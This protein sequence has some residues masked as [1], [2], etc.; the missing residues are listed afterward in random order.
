MIF[1]Q[2][3]SIFFIFCLGLVFF[4]VY[5]PDLSAQKQED[6]NGNW[7]NE[8]PLNFKL[9]FVLGYQEGFKVALGEIVARDKNLP[10]S[11]ENLSAQSL[12]DQ[13]HLKIPFSCSQITE[14][15]NRFYQEDSN[16]PINI[17]SAI[18]IA[19]M[20]LQK[21]SE[22]N[23]QKAIIKYRNANDLFKKGEKTN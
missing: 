9:G 21:C 20:K 6:F 13:F 1:S 23:I 8:V 14:E 5:S 15:I 18:T 3:R 22:E 10:G 11:L 17:Y 12:E 2:K 19:L 4:L 16:K 7:W